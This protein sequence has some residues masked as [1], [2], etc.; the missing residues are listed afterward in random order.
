MSDGRV[1]RPV[2]TT[3]QKDRSRG[4]HPHNG[5]AEAK[6]GIAEPPLSAEEMIPRLKAFLDLVSRELTLAVQYEVSIVSES[7]SERDGAEFARRDGGPRLEKPGSRPDGENKSVMVRFSGEDEEVLLA[8]NGELLLALEYLAHRWLHLPP[9]LHDGV[10]FECGEFRA[11]RLDELKLSARVAAQRVRETGQPFPFNPMSSRDRRTIHLEL[12]G[13]AGVRTISEGSGDY[14][15][16]VI[17][18]ANKK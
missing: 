12:N 6:S 11:T 2:R 4:G 13:A 7:E 9:A 15:H 16:L 3:N 18:P 1:P 17:Y 10:Q 8:R 5:R 14:R